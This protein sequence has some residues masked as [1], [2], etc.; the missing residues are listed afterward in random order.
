V[1]KQA[2]LALLFLVVGMA[3]LS[4]QG[5]VV[6]TGEAKKPDK[7]AAKA[8][9]E[10]TAD[11]ILGV[12]RN[13][14]TNEPV[15]TEIYA[16]EAFFD[17]NKYI[18]TFTGHVKV[19]DPRFN[20][21]SD[22]LTVY[23]RKGENQGMEKAI[24]EGNVGVVRDRADPNGGPVSRAVGRADTATYITAT[25][26]IELKGTPRVQQ[27]PNLHVATSPDTVMIINETGQLTTHGPSRTDMHQEPKSDGGA[28][29]AEAPPKP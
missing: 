10:N 15:T 7:T 2:A 16:D 19:A 14:K 22:K 27:G 12:D 21:Q 26:N 29:K 25:N 18:G 23:V 1:R 13:L 11:K 17:S 8:P 6:A 5:V 28:K 9:T 4:A 3:R 20:L 24:A